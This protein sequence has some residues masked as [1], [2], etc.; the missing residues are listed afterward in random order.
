MEY[1]FKGM[2]LTVKLKEVDK[3]K[4][5]HGLPRGPKGHVLC[6]SHLLG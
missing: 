6:L 2:R 5:E 1:N 3:N 4:V